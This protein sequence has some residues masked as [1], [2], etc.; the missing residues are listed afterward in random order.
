MAC[1]QL[2]KPLIA[3]VF[4]LLRVY[5]ADGWVGVMVAVIFIG[6]HMGWGQEGDSLGN[7]VPRSR[8]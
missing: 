8:G 1:A 2:R 3:L 5:G 6:H 4:P 7:L